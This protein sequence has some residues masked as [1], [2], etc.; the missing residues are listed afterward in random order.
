MRVVQYFLALVLGL[1]ASAD[2]STKALQ[3][4]VRYSVTTGAVVGS[5]SFNVRPTVTASAGVAAG[6]YR[7]YWEL[8]N[9]TTGQWAFSVNSNGTSTSSAPRREMRAAGNADE[10]W[11]TW[12]EGPGGVPFNW[13]GEDRVVI[14]WTDTSGMGIPSATYD[15]TFALH[16]LGTGQ[17][18]Q[19]FRFGVSGSDQHSISVMIGGVSYPLPSFP[20]GEGGATM[21][22]GFEGVWQSLATAQLIVDGSVVATT[23]LPIEAVPT[24]GEGY[25]WLW[26]NV[27]VDEGEDPEPEPTPTPTPTPEPTP[28]PTPTPTPVPVSTPVPKPDLEQ[29]APSPS[30]GPSGPGGGGGGMMLKEDIYETV[31]RAIEDASA[32]KQLPTELPESGQAIDQGQRERLEDV[33]S[34]LDGKSKEWLGLIEGA[35]EKLTGLIDS[36][37][38]DLATVPS[39]FGQN[40]TVTLPTMPVVGALTVNFCFLPHDVIRLIFLWIL[41]FFFFVRI[42]KAFNYN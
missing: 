35:F 31:K 20:G 3:G 21:T 39:G 26:Q 6:T 22:Y 5:D 9:G 2:A 38:E 25:Y 19:D 1:V 42:A 27:P 16:I 10:L 11:V 33:L 24:D 29:A 18:A 32:G 12:I 13:M 40:C 36:M 41:R 28:V 7:V 8:K 4:N 23:Q 17:S 37:I 14:N 30:P 15:E 34:E